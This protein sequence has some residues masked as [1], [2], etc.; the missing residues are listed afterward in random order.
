M[1]KKLI[2][3]GET[4]SLGASHKDDESVWESFSSNCKEK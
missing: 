1:K 3:D 2:T 4:E